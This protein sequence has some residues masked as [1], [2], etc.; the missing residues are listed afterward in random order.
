MN[1]MLSSDEVREHF[2]SLFST[3]REYVQDGWAWLD[4]L[5]YII[6]QF[7]GIRDGLVL[8]C[9]SYNYPHVKIHASKM[10]CICLQSNKFWLH[11]SLY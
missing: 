2:I 1:K 3:G 6:S 5:S 11:L 8:L 7:E 4:L 9:T 10:S